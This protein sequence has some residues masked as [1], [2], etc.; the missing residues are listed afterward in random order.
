VETINT[1]KTHSVAGGS[2]LDQVVIFKC[3]GQDKLDKLCHDVENHI[4]VAAIQR[5][6]GNEDQI[7]I[8]SVLDSFDVPLSVYAEYTGLQVL[9][10]CLG[11][12]ETLN[13]QS[14]KVY[15]MESIAADASLLL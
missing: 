12:T 10:M 3:G 14:E 11:I 6:H 8:I 5:I 13:S 9:T 1:D 2:P 4:R 7:D 15:F